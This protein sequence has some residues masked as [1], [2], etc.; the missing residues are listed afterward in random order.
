MANRKLFA[1]GY[2][3]DGD[4]GLGHR[5]P[6]KQLTELSNISAFEVAACLDYFIFFNINKT[7]LWCAGNNISGKLGIGTPD[8]DDYGTD[9]VMEYTPITYFE[10]NKIK[11]NKICESSTA[12]CTFFISDKVQLY[13]CVNNSSNHNGLHSDG[14]EADVIQPKRIQA[15]KNVIDAQSSGSYAVALCGYNLKY[16]SLIVSFWCRI[17][18]IPGDLM[19]L[20]L[21]YTK[22]TNVYSTTNEVGSGHSRDAVFSNAYG[23]N[24][25]VFFK[26]KNINIIKIR[27]SYHRS[28][29]LDEAGS[30]WVCGRGRLCLG[31]G[32]KDEVEVDSIYIPKE[33]KYFNKENCIKIVNIECGYRHNI[34]LDINGNIYGWGVNDLGQCGFNSD[35]NNIFIPTRIEFFDE[36]IVVE[37]KSRW[38]HNWVKT[39]LG[40]NYMFCCNNYNEC[41]LFEEYPNITMPLRHLY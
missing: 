20:L 40:K 19:R 36:F 5:K 11:I 16:I 29:F 30:V 10:K 9:Q 22:S 15:L 18:K 34:A 26:E 7:K 37:I 12:D 28:F 4:F 13:G 32:D 33:I 39:K 27:I 17:H 2:N 35:G 38:R 3:V 41:L 8:E 31:L 21:I 6:V 24:E 23:W 25:I 1:I 14:N